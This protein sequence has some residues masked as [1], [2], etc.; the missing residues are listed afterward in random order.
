MNNK[1]PQ[2]SFQYNTVPTSD[3]TQNTLF[4]E[5]GR[6]IVPIIFI[7]G[8]MGSNLM[9]KTG[10]LDSKIVWRLDSPLSVLG[11]ALPHYGNAKARKLELA[12]DKTTV[13]DRGEIIEA[14]DDAS[15]RK[16]AQIK[17]HYDTQ[18]HLLGNDKSRQNEVRQLKRERR[19]K[20][21]EA[22]KNTTENR[23]F[24]SR[25]ERGWGTVGFYSY[26]K[27]LNELQTSLFDQRGRIPAKINELVNKSPLFSLDDGAKTTLFFEDDKDIEHCKQ[28][29]FPV[30][31]MGYNWLK[32]NED[33]AMALKELV[34][35]TLPRYYQKRGKFYGKVIIITHSMGGLVSRCYTQALGG[36]DKVL[37]VIH[38]VQPATGAVAAYTRMKRGTEVNTGF[39]GKP[40]AVITENVLGKDAAE[41]TTVCAQAPGPLQL[42]PTPEYGKGWLTITA[43]DGKVESYPKSEPYQ[44]IY[45]AKD[46]WWCACEPHLI[47]PLN[48]DHNEEQMKVDWKEYENIIK[49][50]VK[51]FN[52]AIANQYHPNTYA[53]FG[54]ENKKPIKMSALTYQT[55]QWQGKPISS[56]KVPPKNHIGDQRRLNLKELKGRRTLK[57]GDISEKYTLLPADGNG[58]GTVPQ[59]SGEIPIKYLTAR[60]HFSVEHEPAYQKDKSQ[61][62]TLRAIID[63]VKKVP[64]A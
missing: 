16:V 35:V 20:I 59:H 6:L 50:K 32:S 2:Q 15:D 52:S 31:A 43:P 46:K 37:G 48:S 34:D 19:Q 39:F 29:Y 33:S 45:L 12:P 9:E 18:L 5:K 26:G 44:E 56:H 53:F 47:N 38:G 30:H 14:S 54:I 4:L 42:L 8:V 41:M 24:G 64:L 21:D 13:D 58:D 57:D 25:Q 49:Y 62:F 28:F 27:F 61:D 7:P 22:I 1:K 10:K 51:T 17:H 60:M 63:I 55:A 23:L 3:N 40:K 36:E 11:W